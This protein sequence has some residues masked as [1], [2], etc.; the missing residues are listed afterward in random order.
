M[1]IIVKKIADGQPFNN[2]LKIGGHASVIKRDFYL[3]V[4]KV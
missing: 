1:G 2:R 4:E 3:I